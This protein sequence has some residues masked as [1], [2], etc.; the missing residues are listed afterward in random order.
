MHNY[1][2]EQIEETHEFYLA[3]LREA[4]AQSYWEHQNEMERKA[5]GEDADKAEKQDESDYN[6]DEELPF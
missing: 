6:Y 3:E 2:D 1:G 5:N 4:D